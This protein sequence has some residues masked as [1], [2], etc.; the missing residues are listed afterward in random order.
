MRARLLAAMVVGRILARSGGNPFFIEELVASGIEERDA[1]LPETLSEVIITR[2]ARLSEDAQEVLRIVAA[3]DRPVS[4]RLVASV[5]ERPERALLQPLR[6]AVNSR[7]LVA[8]TS[9]QTYGF[10]HALVREAIYG[11]L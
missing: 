5:A 6:E 9:A 2:V 7:M 1:R 8:D 11:D 10:R 3:A 4:H